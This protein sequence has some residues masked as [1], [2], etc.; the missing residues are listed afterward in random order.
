MAERGKIFADPISDEGLISTIYKNTSNS[1]V[2]EKLT[3]F[4]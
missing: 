4:S 1:I 3:K 2:K